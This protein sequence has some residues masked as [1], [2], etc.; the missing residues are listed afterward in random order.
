MKGTCK[1]FYK[2]CDDC[3]V[4]LAKKWLECTECPIILEHDKMVEAGHHCKM[5]SQRSAK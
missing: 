4:H 5:V 2:E 1:Y 3:P